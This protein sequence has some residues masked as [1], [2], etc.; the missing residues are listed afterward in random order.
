MLFFIVAAPIYLP[1]NRMFIPHPLQ[2][3][4]FVEFLM[5]AVLTCVRW[6]LIILLICTSFHVCDNFLTFTSLSPG[7][8]PSR[9]FSILIW[10]ALDAAPP[11]RELTSLMRGIVEC[12]ELVYI[13]SH[14]ELCIGRRGWPLQSFGGKMF[15]FY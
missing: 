12:T 4:L 13:E 10:Y 15:A 9:V 6:Y 14:T 11:F 3:L 8:L 1:T 5:M 7:N 2:H